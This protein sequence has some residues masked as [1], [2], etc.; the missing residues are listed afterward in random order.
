MGRIGKYVKRVEKALRDAVEE[1]HTPQETAFTAAFATFVALLPTFGLGILFFLVLFKFF[2]RLNKVAVF[3]TVIVF[4]PFVLYTFYALS[5]SLGRLLVRY[6]P[7]EETFEL[8]L[9][10]RAF[11][12]VKTFMAG[13]III[14]STVSLIVYFFVLKAA[15]ISKE[16]EL[17]VTDSIVG[18][19]IGFLPY[20][21]E[22]KEIF[23]K[24]K[25]MIEERFDKC[26]VT[27]VGST[28]IKCLKGKGI[29]DIMV[30]IDNWEMEE[31]L[32]E[33]LRSLGFT[34][35]HAREGER[36]F[37]SRKPDTGYKDVHIHIVKKGSKEEKDFIRFKK[38][39]KNNK[40]LIKSYEELKKDLS[41]ESPEEYTKKK[42][43]W[44]EEKIK[45]T[46]D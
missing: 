11:E 44:I 28:S 13:N 5:Y 36:R 46:E 18:R 7:L 40:E 15:K 27:H 21:E 34:H 38:L 10:T 4:N 22:F 39:L 30:S 31:E 29:V 42:G 1:D 2:K 35:I 12:A 26:D 25:K 8:A 45:G 20:N 9:R 17:S 24:E 19:N 37:L 41:Y 16:R 14:A 33:E 3:G 32:L 43:R 6:P 23:R